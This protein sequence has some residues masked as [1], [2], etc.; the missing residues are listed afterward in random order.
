MMSLAEWITVVSVVGTIGAITLAAFIYL[1]YMIRK[2]SAATAVAE[3]KAKTNAV[4]VEKLQRAN[5]IITTD[6]DIADVADRLRR[7]NF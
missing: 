1:I 5:D 2:E 3:E 7:G 4:A 6:R